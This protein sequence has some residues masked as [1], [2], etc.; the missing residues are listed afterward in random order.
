MAE[1]LGDQVKPISILLLATKWQFDTYGLSTVNKS[2]VNNLREVDSQGEKIKIT[3]AVVEEDKNIKDDQREDAAK[4]KVKLRGGKPPRGA[5]RKPKTEQKP[6]IEWLDQNISTYYP[7]LR[8]DSYDFIIGHVPYLANGPLNLRD[9][10]PET[11]CKPKVILMIHDI[12]KTTDR[13]TDEE[14]LLEWLREADI[15]FSVGQEVEAEI[16]SSIASLPPEEKPIHKLYIPSYPLELFNVHRDVVK[17]NKIQGT[18]SVT[19]MTGERKDLDISGLNFALAVSSAASASKHIKDFD[20]VKTNFVVL[21]NLKEDKEQ[22]KQEFS[23]LIQKGESDGCSLYFQ[24][25]APEN[26]EK[27]KTHMRKSNLFILPLKP[28]SP[29]FGSEALS[30][31]AA[32]VPILVSNHAGMASVLQT[33][34]QDAS[35]LKKSDIETWKDGILQMLLRPEDSQRRANKL[36]EE[37]LL[38][39][40]IAQTHR[41]FIGTIVGEKLKI[42][43]MFTF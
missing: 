2:L 38:E 40:S 1:A 8:K 13:D 35:I 14:T 10:Y 37:L 36:R 12:P 32:G 25:D 4:Y 9:Q 24:S 39:T 22:W 27:L 15:V 6:S 42:C 33:V 34:F 23:K 43:M 30:A 26:L 16:I 29:L 3:C 28:D 20:G 11:K 5:N 31:V 21:T 17:E 41:D 7:D 19:L 18:Q